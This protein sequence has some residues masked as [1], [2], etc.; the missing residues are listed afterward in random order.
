MALQLACR[1][2]DQPW[3]AQSASSVAG[4]GV[5]ITEPF[6]SSLGFCSLGAATYRRRM[7]STMEAWDGVAVYSKPNT[8]ESAVP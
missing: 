7:A 5:G 8:I 4:A 3:L 6:T 1:W 2:A